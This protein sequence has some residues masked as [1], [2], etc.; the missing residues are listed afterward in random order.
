M[1]ERQDGGERRRLDR[2]P[3]ERYAAPAGG[4]STRRDG[5]PPS[6]ARATIDAAI[7]ADAGAVL[8]FAL[9]LLDLGAGLV[10]VA[11]FTGWATALALVWWGR[12]AVPVVR[13]RVAVGVALGG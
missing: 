2:A 1:S 11:A 5:R 13:T 3:G 7:V 10:V 8:F 9:G 12:E 6:M 4:A